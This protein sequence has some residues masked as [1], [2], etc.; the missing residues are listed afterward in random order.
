MKQDG[1]VYLILIDLFAFSDAGHPFVKTTCGPLR[2]IPV[3]LHDSAAKYL[4]KSVDMPLRGG[5]QN[6]LLHLATHSAGIP[7]NPDNMTGKDV[8]EQYETYTVE[9]MYAFLSDY[10]LTRDPGTEFEYLQSYPPRPGF[11]TIHGA[12]HCQQKRQE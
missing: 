9:K 11:L 3:G 6:T 7:V 5:K 12:N 4:P 8:R 1:C 10:T 2:T